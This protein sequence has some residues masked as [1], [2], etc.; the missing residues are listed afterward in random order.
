LR[1][2]RERIVAAAQAGLSRGERPAVAE[3]AARAGVSKSTFY[4]A[5][6]SRREL[7]RVLAAEPEPDSRAAMLEAAAELLARDGLGRLSMEEVAQRAGVSRARLYRTFP[8]KA[9]LFAA[10]VR[11]FSPIELVATT[12]ER[13]G[14]EPPETALPELAVAVWRAISTHLGVIRPLLFEVTSFGPDVRDFVLGEAA[15]LILGSLGGYLLAQMENGR[16][17]RVHPLLAVQSFVGP[18]I[19]HVLMR[20]VVTEGLGVELDP[21]EAVRLFAANWVRGMRP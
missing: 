15:P 14:D 12:I 10:M 4:R 17:R 9:A 11:T 3:I 21:E 5:F 6:G 13:I 16:L 8:G 2:S 20:P 18:I 1:N 19:V 7:F